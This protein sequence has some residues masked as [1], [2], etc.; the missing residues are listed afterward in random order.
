MK[1]ARTKVQEK[2]NKILLC[3]SKERNFMKSF[4]I[5][6]FWKISMCFIFCITILKQKRFEDMSLS[7]RHYTLIKV[8]QATHHQDDVRYGASRGIQCLCMSLISV[9]WT[10][11]NKISW[12][13]SPGL[14]NQFDLDCILGKG[15]Q[16]FKF[17]GKFRYLQVEDLP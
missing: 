13:K 9:S 6:E 10:S 8:I 12:F 15:D 1:K 2:W 7:I 14:W 5:V 4:K 16:L 17:V 11:K 3:R